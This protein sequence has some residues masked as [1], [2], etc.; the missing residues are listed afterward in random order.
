MSGRQ[1]LRERSDEGLLGELDFDE[2]LAGGHHV[3]ILDTHDTTAPLLEELGV[4]V[5]LGL[6]LLAELLEVDEVLALHLSEGD[7]GGGLEVDKLAEVGLAT[8][9]AEGN[10]LLSAESGQVD[11]DLNGVDVVGDDDELGLVLLNEG[12]H[13]VEAELK[14]NRLVTLLGS[15][16]VGSTALSLVLESE[17]LLLVL[18][19]LVLGEQFKELSGCSS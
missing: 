13:V 5:V 6:E 1:L 3:L 2:L 9:E 4:V 19:W 16:L 15:A 7:A 11:D 17:C 18:L 10:T 12:G 8:D 14:V